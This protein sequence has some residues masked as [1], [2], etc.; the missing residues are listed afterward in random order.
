MDQ[1]RDIYKQART[2]FTDFVQNLIDR[3]AEFD[4]SLPLQTMSQTVFRINRD[5]RFAKNKQPYKPF[6][7]W[8][9]A[10]EGGKKSRKACY[11]VHIQP[12]NRSLIAW[13]IRMPDGPVLKALRKGIA[14]DYKKLRRLLWG[15][16][17]KYFGDMPGKKLKTRPKGYALDHP[18]LDLLNLTSHHFFYEFNDKEVLAKDFTQKVID[19]F[20]RMKKVHRFYNKILDM[21]IQNGELDEWLVKKEKL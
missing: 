7:A 3:R 13:W 11:Y 6:M 2:I 15:D 18:A 20:A 12:G 9:L 1:H 16:F 17:R 5:I 21:A 14:T 4:K 8:A 10:P 19:G